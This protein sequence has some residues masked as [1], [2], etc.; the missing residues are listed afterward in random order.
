[1]KTTCLFLRIC[2]LFAATLTH[3]ATNEHLVSWQGGRWY[4]SGANV[5][6]FNYGADFGIVEEWG[7]FNAYNHTTMVNICQQL[8]ADGANSIRWFVF[9]DG[10]GSP[11]FSSTNGGVV[12]GFDSSVLTNLADAVATAS[13]HGI[14]L[15]FSLWDFAIL[16]ADSIPGEFGEH[17][18]GH[19]NLIVDDIAYGSFVTNALIPMLN[20]PIPGSPRTLGTHPNVLALEIMNEPEWGVTES[21]AVDYRVEQAVS[22]EQMRRFVARTAGEIHRRANCLVTVG[23]AAMK[24]S[25][26]H[27]HGGQSNFWNDAALQVYDPDGHLDFHSPHYY[28]WMDGDFWWSFSP[29]H[30]GNTWS[31]V[32][33]KPAVIGEFSANGE[34]KSV[35][36]VINAIAAQGYGGA[37]CW[38]Y[39]GVDGHG[40]WLNAQAAYQRF[41][42]SNATNIVDPHLRDTDGDGMLNHDEYL[43]GAD[44]EDAGSLLDIAISRGMSGP[45]AAFTGR[46]AQGTGY[47]GVRRSYTIQWSTN[48]AGLWRMLINGFLATNATIRMALP[49]ATNA[50][51]VFL[52]VRAR[53]DV[54]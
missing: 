28:A 27:A 36:N 49:G 53:L 22:L 39:R 3:A 18:G 19:R 1:M 24:W 51:P 11:E 31:N 9:C 25:S 43:A 35:T 47:G 23:S 40:S 21:A 8:R 14:Y 16:F 5:A 7:N 37:W 38:S 33:D 6:W 54:K 30:P 13:E 12:T 50:Q 48:L 17:A 2:T 52:R 29:L 46:L 34:N 15:V 26:D 32:F 42:A 4:L 44:A 45:E 41:N 20:Q 10:R